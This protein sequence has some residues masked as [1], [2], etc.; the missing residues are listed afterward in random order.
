MRKCRCGNDVARNAKFC[1]K[2]GHRFST[3][4]FTVLLAFIIVGVLIWGMAKASGLGPDATTAAPPPLTKEQQAAKDKQDLAFV[5]AVAGARQLKASVRNPDSF[6][7]GETLVMADGAVCY[8]YRAQNG[9]GG[10]NVGQAVLAPSGKFKTNNSDGFTS[11]W[12]KECGGKTGTDKTW[13]IGYSAGFH[14]LL[15]D[16]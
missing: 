6:K 8:D 11:L 10:M 5:R 15:D 13:E 12:N 16:K 4:G 2:C 1:P 9:F 14:G 7:L 3:S